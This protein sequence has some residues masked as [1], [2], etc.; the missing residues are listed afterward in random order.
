M[1]LGTGSAYLLL[2]T[3]LPAQDLLSTCYFDPRQIPRTR[4]QLLTHPFSQNP[5]VVLPKIQE[6]SEL[7]RDN[8]AI[9]NNNSKRRWESKAE[10]RLVVATPRSLIFILEFLIEPWGQG[11]C[12]Y[13][14]PNC[15]MMACLGQPGMDAS[16]L[17]LS[18]ATEGGGEMESQI[19]PSTGGKRRNGPGFTFCSQF[20][21]RFL[22]LSGIF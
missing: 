1:P 4:S 8:P 7:P 16:G 2:I 5:E 19:L 6:K 14:L 20:V 13:L 15:L 22:C 12:F 17:L 9:M 18:K 3:K 11:S 10:I 21:P